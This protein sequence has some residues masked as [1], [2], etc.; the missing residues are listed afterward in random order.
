ME[1]RDMTEGAKGREEE[2]REEKEERWTLWKTN[3]IVYAN[4][5]ELKGEK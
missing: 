3:M 5:F 1:L 2:R 4:C